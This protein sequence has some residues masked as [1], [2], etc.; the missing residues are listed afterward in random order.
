MDLW[1]FTG[2]FIQSVT[3]LYPEVLDHDV[4]ILPPSACFMRQSQCTLHSSIPKHSIRNPRQ[5]KAVDGEGLSLLLQLGSHICFSSGSE[6]PS[7]PTLLSWRSAGVKCET[8]VCCLCIN[9]PTKAE[10]TPLRIQVRGHVHRLWHATC[11]GAATVNKAQVKPLK[12]C[13]HTHFFSPRCCR[14][15]QPSGGN[16]LGKMYISLT[17]SLVPVHLVY[18]TP[19][20]YNCMIP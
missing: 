4:Y 9:L 13:L 15:A 7:L 14:G 16:Y 1:C 10:E 3:L 18:N 11:I 2:R 20:E 5:N 19:V 8:L 12:T 6:K 17:T